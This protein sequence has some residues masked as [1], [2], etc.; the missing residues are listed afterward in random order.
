MQVNLSCLSVLVDLL[1]EHA[2]A[3]APGVK[4]RRMILQTILPQVGTIPSWR[5]AVGILDGVRTS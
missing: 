5:S 1:E 4:G 2:K 3:V